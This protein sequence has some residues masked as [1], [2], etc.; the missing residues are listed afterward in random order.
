MDKCEIFI[1][2]KKKFLFFPIFLCFL[3]YPLCSCQ[4]QYGVPDYRDHK[5]INDSKQYVNYEKIYVLEQKKNY[6]DIDF[7]KDVFPNGEIVDQNGESYSLLDKYDTLLLLTPSRP[8]IFTD[9]RCEYLGP[10]KI[11][12]R[13][14]DQIE[15]RFVNTKTYQQS[16]RM[17]LGHIRFADTKEFVHINEIKDFEK[18]K[19]ESIVCLDA[20]IDFTDY[21]LISENKTLFPKSFGGVFLNPEKHVLKNIDIT[22]V[23][24][25]ESAFISRSSRS[26]WYDSLII[27]NVRYKNYDESLG[28]GQSKFALVS[29]YSYDTLFKDLKITNFTCDGNDFYLSTISNECYNCDFI[30]CEVSGKILNR[31]QPDSELKDTVFNK[32]LLMSRTSGICNEFLSTFYSERSDRF[33]E[34]F[35]NY[36]NNKSDANLS[37]IKQDLETLSSSST[38]K[39]VRVDMDITGY[40]KTGSFCVSGDKFLDLTTDFSSTGKLEGLHTGKLFVDNYFYQ[41]DGPVGK[42]I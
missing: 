39:N 11:R 14:S 21:D 2:S 30:N 35:T 20:D 24:Q 3:S 13:I 28:N 17:K 5:W 25:S 23:K 22:T 41:I 26:A 10:M 42:L 34:D 12:V 18:I 29:N 19:D 36:Y 9:K 1:K 32:P 4:K 27:D 38:I 33:D 15:F 7:L 8:D 40:G 6:V 16:E 31:Y 37:Q